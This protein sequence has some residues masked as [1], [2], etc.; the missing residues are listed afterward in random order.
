MQAAGDSRQ[1]P[2][3]MYKPEPIEDVPD[4]F[5]FEN[6]T[7]VMWWLLWMHFASYALWPAA[8]LGDF[9]A[10]FWYMKSMRDFLP[11][12]VRISSE[13]YFNRMNGVTIS[14]QNTSYYPPPTNWTTFL[15]QEE[16]EEEL[17]AEVDLT[18]SN[19]Q[20]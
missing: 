13:Q 15:Q 18:K 8:F 9:E 7:N 1:D 12:A 14:M 10:F 6:L 4:N 3:I 5:W 17:N 19:P 2:I 16:E 20:V 11:P